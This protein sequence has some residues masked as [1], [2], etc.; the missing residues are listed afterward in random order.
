MRIQITMIICGM[1]YDIQR[2]RNR[3]GKSG[4]ASWGL[5]DG[6]GGLRVDS[7]LCD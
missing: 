6:D 2:K 5:P 3:L 1:E 7:N 4:L